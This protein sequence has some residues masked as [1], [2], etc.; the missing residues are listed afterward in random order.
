MC[1]TTARTRD[2][3]NVSIDA[4][5]I[6]ALRG[7]IRGEVLTA[8][9]QGYDAARRVWNAMIDRRPA[10]IARCHGAADVLAAVNF[11]R[12]HRLLL[13]VR[14]G[15]HNVAG[16]AVCADGL[17][18]DLSE[19]R[20]L[21]VDVTNRTARVEPGLTWGDFDRETGAFGLTTTGGTVSSTGIA[22]L[23]LGGGIGWHA[24]RHGFACD[25]LLSADIVTADGRLL[26]V[27][28]SQ[29]EDLFWAV[30]GG[31]GNF[32]VVTSF[33]FR[34]HPAPSLVTGGMIFYPMAQAAEA[35]RF[36]RDY[37]S[38]AEDDLTA[39]AAFLTLPDGTPAFA[40]AAA[41]FGARAASERAL[42]PLRTFGSPLMDLIAEMPYTALQSM[43]DAAAPLGL[44]RYWKSGFLPELSDATL[45]LVLDHATRRTSPYSLVL[46]FHI[47]GA[48][49]RHAP[50]ETA[51]GARATQWD[52]DIVPQWTSAAEDREQIAWARTFW[53][54]VEPATRGVYVNHLDGD[55]GIARV[56][57]AY[58]ANFERLQKIKQAYDPD[59]MFGA[60]GGGR[61]L[62]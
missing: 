49:A 54:A 15:G 10:L 32:G 43:F 5:T 8:D 60:A 20:G 19:M 24:A 27:G 42:A 44:R 50:D 47:H 4:S 56:R 37:S 18:I 61:R 16:A 1:D 62:S 22:G 26:T 13:S 21:R 38:R 59:D 17:M 23:T 58:G 3:R 52:L 45:D 2:G 46:F 53:N 14:G 48:A 40:I 28:P 30:R 36:Y 33:E 7:C 11:A 12:L 57:A 29:H 31:G 39:Y 34:L 35:L 51:F 25:N 9:Q 55:D 6:E 41:W